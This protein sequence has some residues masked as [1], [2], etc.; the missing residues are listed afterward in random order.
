MSDHNAIL[1][2]VNVQRP[3]A[4][5]KVTSSRNI[6]N[7]DQQAFQDH[8]NEK[9]NYLYANADDANIVTE[10]YENAIRATLDIHAPATKRSCTN[11][12]CQP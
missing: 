10:G 8:F 4:Q 6:K 5:K 7:I 11:R 12:A 3:E 9:F 2:K 1:C